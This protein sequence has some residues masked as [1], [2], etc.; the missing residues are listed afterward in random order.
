MPRLI[1]A[2]LIAPLIPAALAALAVPFAGF[3]GSFLG[4]VATIAVLYGYPAIA[5]IGIPAFLYFRHKGWLRWWQIL[6][7]G[8]T[9][10]TLLPI[11]VV[12]LLVVL[13]LS[14]ATANPSNLGELFGESIAMLCAGAAIGAICAFGFWI[15]ARRSAYVP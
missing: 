6:L 5:V 12:G 2:F 3:D 11:V 10:G 9:I 13:S 8:A 1:A 4:P 15:I 7:A 14:G